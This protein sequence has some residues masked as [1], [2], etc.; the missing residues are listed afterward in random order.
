MTPF[1]TNGDILV[2]LYNGYGDAVLALPALRTLRR[3]FP[4]S[5]IYIVCREEHR[6]TVF[7]GIEIDFPKIHDDGANARLAGLS[8]VVPHCIVSWNAYFPCAVDAEIGKRF[9]H[10]PRWGFCDSSG[11]LTPLA[12]S[13]AEAHMR[14]QYFH[15]LGLK[16]EYSLLD[17][18]VCVSPHCEWRLEEWLRICGLNLDRSRYALHL[19]ST[20]D[21]MWPVEDWVRLVAYIWSEWNLAPLI[22]GEDSIHSRRLLEVFR[23]ARKLPVQLGI[24]V[25]FA[26][27]RS[28]V[29]FVGI[30]SV[31]A[32]IADSFERPAMVLFGAADPRIWGP[33]GYRSVTVRGPT[34]GLLDDLEYGEAQ[35]A[36][37]HLFATFALRDI[38]RNSRTA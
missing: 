19:D 8:S 13:S 30:D 17:R 21:K 25:H 15:V 36:A 27:V 11:A 14:D 2:S 34:G 3:R 32:H 33:V 9:C 31:F 29:A 20:E 18:Q 23:F 12:R 26:A 37:T 22:I 35:Q 7:S 16:P 4:A 6:S 38:D 24:G 28:A 1:H 10:V 5:N